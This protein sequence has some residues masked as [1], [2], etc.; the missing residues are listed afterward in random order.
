MVEHETRE[1]TAGREA[2]L[3]RTGTTALIVAAVAVAALGTC[4][5]I[6]TTRTDPAAIAGNL[7]DRYLA[8]AN[9]NAGEA[10]APLFA[11]DGTFDMNGMESQGHAAIAADVNWW[12]PNVE[13]WER[14]GDVAETEE[15][16]FRFAARGDYFG[17]PRD[18]EGEIELD[19]SLIAQLTWNGVTPTD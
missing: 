14:V 1:R 4:S 15:G 5:V 12:S 19:G 3:A 7:A 16:A 11:E 13:N 9:A 8:E 17:D 10:V 2:R 6:G 18:G